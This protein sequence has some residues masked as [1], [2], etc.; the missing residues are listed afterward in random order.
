LTL[1]PYFAW[2][3]SSVGWS[4]VF[5]SEATSMYEPQL[6]KSTTFSVS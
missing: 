5:V 3:W 2:N 1:I 4:L 6:W